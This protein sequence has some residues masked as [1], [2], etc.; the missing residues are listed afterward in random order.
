M[1]IEDI[2][3]MDK[4]ILTPA[5]VAAVLHADAKMIRWQAKNEPSKLGFAVSRV[6]TRTKIPR[7]AFIVWFLKGVEKN[8]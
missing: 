2:I 4:P 5:E 1:T 7:L 3:N 8:E 6:G